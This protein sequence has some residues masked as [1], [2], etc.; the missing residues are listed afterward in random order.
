MAY[1][2]SVNCTTCTNAKTGFIASQLHVFVHVCVCL[3]AHVY[4]C[5]YVTCVYTLSAFQWVFGGTHKI[6]GSVLYGP[7]S[8]AHVSIVRTNVEWGMVAQW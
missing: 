4:V 8:I 3:S 1:Q 5:M 2:R 6:M 7:L